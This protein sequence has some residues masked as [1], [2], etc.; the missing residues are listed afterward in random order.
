VYNKSVINYSERFINS[1]PSRALKTV[2]YLMAG[3]YKL[4]EFIVYAYI[5]DKFKAVWEKLQ[6]YFHH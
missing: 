6:A 1:K 5:K 2:E 4:W 3:I